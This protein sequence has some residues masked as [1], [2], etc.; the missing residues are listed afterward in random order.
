MELKEQ[1]K[2]HAAA[3]KQ[4]TSIPSGCKAC[5]RKG[6]PIF[7]L[8]VAAVPKGLLNSNWQP[9]V[10]D[11]GVDLQGG[12]FKYALRTLRAGYLY[13]LLDNV[14]WQGYEVTDEGH[15]RQ[16]TPLAMP[17]GESIRPLTRVC[18]TQNHEIVAG[19]INIDEKCQHAA[20]AFSS[21]PWSKE[22]LQAYA[23]GKCPE[24]RFTHIDVS[25]LKANPA[26]VPAARI[27]D[28]SLVMLKQN[29]A[30]FAVNHLPNIGDMENGISGGAHGFYPRMDRNKQN[31]L[32][33]HISRME[34]QYECKN[35]TAVVLND[36]VGVVQ[37]LNIGRLQ[38]IEAYQAQIGKPEILHKH[39]ISEAIARYMRSLEEVI[40]KNSEAR[41]ERPSSGYPMAF[42]EVMSKEN[43]AKLS[44][45][46]QYERL[47]KSYNEADRAAFAA[48]YKLNADYWK[49]RIKAVGGDLAIWYQS[50]KWLDVIKDDYA[51]ERYPT[52]WAKQFATI[53]ACIQGGATD[54]EMDNVWKEWI[55]LPN[56]PAY[57]GLLVNQP[58]ALESLYNSGANYSNLKTFA[59]S[60]EIGNYLKSPWIQN[61]IAARLTALSGSASRV[62]LKLDDTARAGYS[63]MV[64]GS[65][66]ATTGYQPI[67]FKIETVVGKAQQYIRELGLLSPAMVEN[68]TPF[69]AIS[70]GGATSATEALMAITDKHLLERPVTLYL[71]SL[72]SLEEQRIPLNKH[73]GTNPEKVAVEPLGNPKQIPRFKGVNVADIVF[74]TD[75]NRVNIE[76]VMKE[77]ASRYASG[78]GLG[79]ILSAG[80]LCLQLN[81]WNTNAKNLKNAIGDDMDLRLKYYINRL[82]VLSA[83]AEIAGFG[84]MLALKNNAETL[85]ANYVHPLIKAGG[86]IAGVSSIVD[87]VRIAILSQNASKAG[88]E[89]AATLYGLAALVTI[90]GGSISTVGAVLGLFTLFG[91]TGIGAFLILSGTLIALQADQL[92]STA[93]EV[94]LRRCCFG[95]PRHQDVRWYANNLEDLKD[96][97]TAF[98]AIVN[99]MV[100]EVGFGGLYDIQGTHYT[101]LAIHLSFPAGKEATSAW[102]LRL[103]AGAENTLMLAET[104]NI[105]AKAD[106]RQQAPAS[107]FLSQDYQRS[108]QDNTLDIRA[109]IW[110]NE[111]RYKNAT[112]EINYWPDK[113]D[114]H[115]QQSLLVKAEN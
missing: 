32:S 66:Y 10:P 63:H 22:V 1:I 5:E 49:R 103:T 50:R 39:F 93:F 83:S 101:K 113:N 74:D 41:Y 102:E 44:F 57:A 59:G 25:A 54:Q 60:D 58:S 106:N 8:R 110:V 56:S 4:A 104:H 24:T 109:E 88:D 15:L 76:K 19:F 92:R 107:T 47:K 43:V 80:M 90:T 111:N 84:R 48:Q 6:I 73:A 115:Y 9:N 78:N 2:L 3:S 71:S 35:I 52:S 34:N 94:W 7:P 62:M 79:I 99:G 21:D 51:P 68:K 16:F 53:T 31:A 27:M 14:V 61:A 70:R 29:V 26:N 75:I 28:S 69:A 13:V 98:N 37:E 64:E 87:G 17:E 82:M 96:A 105:P 18:R 67:L 23:N 112:L 38:L 20:L 72:K 55:K 108:V 42:N 81:D 95:I 89:E 86:V 45:N 33:D 77:R 65:I 85:G 40:T 100:A 114:Q 12:E 91:P 97:L 36:A 30:E 46:E 11:Q